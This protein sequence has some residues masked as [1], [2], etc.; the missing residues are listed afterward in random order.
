[1]QYAERDK[2]FDMTYFK[3][4]AATSDI[5]LNL[6]NR[7]KAIETAH[8]G[9]ANPQEPNEAFWSQKAKMW[10]VTSAEARTMRCGNCAAFN[11]SPKMLNCIRDGLPVEGDPEA[12]IGAG[13]LGYC[14]MF[15][16]KCASARTCDAWVVG[17]P[18][19]R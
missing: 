11:V 7:Q 8:Y 6:K 12:V 18:I 3:C 9:P 4:P 1:M 19:S 13:Q 15:A 10:G 5:A 16:F 14:Q 17:G 2:E